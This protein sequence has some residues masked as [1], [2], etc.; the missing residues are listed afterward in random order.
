MAN[1]K[2]IRLRIASVSSTKQ[3]TSAMKVV[4]AAKLRKAQDAIINLRPYANKLSEVV[5]RLV[6]NLPVSENIF[7]RE[8]EVH[9]V[10]LVVITSNRGMCGAFNSSVIKAATAKAKGEYGNLLDQG[11]VHFLCIGKKAADILKGRKMPVVADHSK[12][13]DSLTEEAVFPLAYHLITQ[14]GKGEY[15]RIEL[16]YNQFKN[17]A[18]Y[19]LIN[20]QYLP[21]IP[22][23]SGTNE[24]QDYIYEPSQEEILEKVIPI[25][26]EIQLLKALLDSNAAEHG[27][28]MTAMHKATD[29]ATE[30]IKSLT[31]N[32]NKA[33]QAAITNE[34]SEIVSGAESLKN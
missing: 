12:L 11:N 1:L 34:L 30:L 25:S 23:A 13:F 29:N 15:D 33:R 10:L 19:N 21:F 20:E 24:V 9:K 26:L 18:V 7:A 6:D 17:A 28:R 31:L 4:S 32:Y 5:S 22:P 14:Y 3:I 2:E 8:R 16:F 27:A